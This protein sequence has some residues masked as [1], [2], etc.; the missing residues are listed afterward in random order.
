MEGFL[1]GVLNFLFVLF[2]YFFSKV[3]KV[4]ISQTQ[5][6][7]MKLKYEPYL[8]IIKRYNRRAAI[9]FFRA[10]E[11]SCN[12]GASI[13]ILSTTHQKKNSQGKVFPPRKC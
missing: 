8:P 13:N 2:V 6:Y 5:G 1:P 7:T 3:N 12:E 4:Q 10:G 9:Y 11:I